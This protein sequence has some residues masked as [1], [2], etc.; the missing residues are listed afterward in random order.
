MTDEEVKRGPNR[1]PHER[2]VDALRKLREHDLDPFC[3][4]L[5]EESPLW[6][7]AIAG[8]LVE[9]LGERNG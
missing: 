9:Q 3:A 4:S 7:E 5:V 6:A 8:K 1:Q 2:A